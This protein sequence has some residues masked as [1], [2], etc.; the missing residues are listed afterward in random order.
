MAGIT[1]FAAL[2]A[3]DGRA[4]S[5]H[6]KAGFAIGGIVERLQNKIPFFTRCIGKGD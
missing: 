6:Y 5:L 4:N 1:T 3:K 2:K